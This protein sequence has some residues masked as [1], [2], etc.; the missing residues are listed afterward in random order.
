MR[1]QSNR[2]ACLNQNTNA[3]H[4]A[5]QHGE[6]AHQYELRRYFPSQSLTQLIS[7][8]WFLRYHFIPPASRQQTRMP[9]PHFH[10]VFENGQLD[11]VGPASK[12]KEYEVSGQNEVLGVKFNIGALI[13]WLDEQPEH[14]IDKTLPAGDVL[15]ID[16]QGLINALQQAGS[17]EQR[18]MAYQAYLTLLNTNPSN[19]LLKIRSLIEH[20]QSS[21]S[22][23]N[24]TQLMQQ[25]RESPDAVEASF[26][27]YVGF[28][29]AWI[30]KK[31]RLPAAL[32]QLN[33]QQVS[34]DELVDSMEYPDQFQ[35]IRDFKEMLGVIPKDHPR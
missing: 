23:V 1:I 22:L 28:S 29:P 21:P 20:I 12:A 10:L 5:S 17:D 15:P 33:K 11:L 30:I 32:H 26:T 16:T 35:L 8:F 18:V 2:G 34:I 3:N 7:Q 14:F 24:I 27:Q 4:D 19:T 6:S 13:P 9:D 25:C 31:C